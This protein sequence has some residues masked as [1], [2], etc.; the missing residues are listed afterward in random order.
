[1]K[2]RRKVGIVLREA[3][4]AAALAWSVLT[5]GFMLLSNIEMMK[6]H[7]NHLCLGECAREKN[8]P[9]KIRIGWELSTDLDHST[10][11]DVY[12]LR[13]RRVEE[14]L[15][16]V[17]GSYLPSRTIYSLL[18]DRLPWWGFA[19]YYEHLRSNRLSELSAKGKSLRGNEVLNP[20]YFITAKVLTLTVENPEFSWNKGTDP[21]EE[22]GPC[23]YFPDVSDV[24]IYP[25]DRKA[26]ITY[27]VTSYK[28]KL[29]ANNC[30]KKPVNAKEV[31]ID[32]D[33]VNAQDFGLK[34]LA[35]S[36]SESINVLPDSISENPRRLNFFYHQGTS[37]QQPSGCNN[38]SPMVREF[39][40]I[41]TS[42]L[43][44][45]LAIKFWENEPAS[46]TAP[47]GLTYYINFE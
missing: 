11:R 46:P 23:L 1:M 39:Q 12:A 35:F 21:S 5:Q 47:P 7:E 26:E 30:L 10:R 16:L 29:D 32:I 34:Y 37:C 2:S 6:A 44:A 13:Q 8:L 24:T 28:Q 45:R 31:L 4:L 33:P 15:P 36:R 43:P 40:E 27:R 42:D 19:G 18:K 17:N 22:V 9:D 14:Q 41:R 25:S 38:L 20:F 3:A